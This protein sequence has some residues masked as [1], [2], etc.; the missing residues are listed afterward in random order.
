LE[1]GTT[2]SARGVR[3]C[4]WS[5]AEGAAHLLHALL[6]EP[7]FRN[8]PFHRPAVSPYLAAADMVMATLMM[9]NEKAHGVG[10]PVEQMW[11]ENDDARCCQAQVVQ[12]RIQDIEH[13]PASECPTSEQQLSIG[14][15][16]DG[17]RQTCKA[18][19]GLGLLVSLDILLPRTT[20]PNTRPPPHDSNSLR[21]LLGSPWGWAQ[22]RQ[23]GGPGA[24]PS[25]LEVRQLVL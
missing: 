24:P 21:P 25:D 14:L 12:A 5:I 17:R 22:M 8:T 18:V 1:A 9:E 6:V 13:T 20:P 23:R 4:R 16:G 7:A 2:L 19:V 10:V 11:I 3:G 15:Q